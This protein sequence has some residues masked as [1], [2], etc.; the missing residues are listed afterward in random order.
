MFISAAEDVKELHFG[1]FLTKKKPDGKESEVVYL[2]YFDWFKI[3]DK[4][5]VR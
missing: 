3:S 4:V 2:I 1:G 5:N